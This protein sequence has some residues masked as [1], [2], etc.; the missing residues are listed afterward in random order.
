MKP[1]SYD[2]TSGAPSPETTIRG[3]VDFL[4]VKDPVSDA[5]VHIR[6]QDTSRADSP[7]T[8]VAEQVIDHV[9][10]VP[11]G[12]PLPFTL[13]MPANENS[14]YVVRVHADVT[15]DGKVSRGDYVSTQS[16]PVDMNDEQSGI[17][18]VVRRVG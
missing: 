7:A 3:T 10:I 5:T 16:Y 6:L 11:D 18:I 13:Q 17:T 2:Q 8:T 4:D 14:R 9:N 1:N 12:Q 15:G